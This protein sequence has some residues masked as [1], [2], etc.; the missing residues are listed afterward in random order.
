MDECPTNLLNVSSCFS[1]QDLLRLVLQCS[2]LMVLRW[3]VDHPSDT[4]DDITVGLS[5]EDETGG[6]AA[7]LGVAR[8]SFGGPAATPTEVP[9]PSEPNPAEDKV[10]VKKRALKW[11]KQQVQPFFMGRTF[12][13]GP[14]PGRLPKPLTKSLL[15]LGRPR[16]VLCVSSPSRHTTG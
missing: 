9:A 11:V 12:L 6:L 3:K 7:S 13:R 4:E 8:H 10:V 14:R 5:S 1:F 15:S 16:T 2:E